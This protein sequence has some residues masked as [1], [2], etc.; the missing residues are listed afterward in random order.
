MDINKE[1]LKKLITRKRNE[2]QK[3]LIE[4]EP[5]KVKVKYFKKEKIKKL[6][7]DYE[8]FLQ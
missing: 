2:I 8:M 4:K 7:L 5:K 1:D 3:E 6:N